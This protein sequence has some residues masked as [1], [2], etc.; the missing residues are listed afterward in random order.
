MGVGGGWPKTQKAGHCRIFFRRPLW[1]LVRWLTMAGGFVLCVCIYVFVF[2]LCAFVFVYV[3]F[4]VNGRCKLCL[5]CL[6]AVWQ[7]TDSGSMILSM[8]N[9]I[10][11]RQRQKSKSKKWK[12]KFWVPVCVRM[13]RAQCVW[14]GCQITNNHSHNQQN[15]KAWC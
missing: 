7:V 15:Q 11:V 9:N 6:L 12:W 10:T 8:H 14:R 5:L 4:M 13:R 1:L 2:A 3:C